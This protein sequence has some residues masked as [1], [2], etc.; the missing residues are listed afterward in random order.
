M[1]EMAARG[2]AAA[3][4]AAQP[5]GGGA[6]EERTGCGRQRI[7][8]GVLGSERHFAKKAL[9]I[10]LLH[11]GPYPLEVA[12]WAASGR[13][14]AN[15]SRTAARL[16]V[17]GTDGR[18][19]PTECNLS[20][21]AL[22]RTSATSHSYATDALTRDTAVT[23]GATGAVEWEAHVHRLFGFNLKILFEAKNS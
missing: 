6:G 14:H 11:I 1:V 12:K 2:V 20:A 21:G 7:G 17:T 4:A 23:V 5:L 19:M 22:A 16:S 18:T 10:P 13:R 9:R 15:C 8:F 3:A